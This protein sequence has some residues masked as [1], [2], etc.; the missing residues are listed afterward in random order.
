LANK[1]LTFLDTSVLINAALGKDPA[2][3][4]RALS[5][6]SDARREFASSFFLKLELLPIPTFHKITA[7]VRLYQHYF[8]NVSVWGD[9]ADFVQD[10]YP[11]AEQYGL[12]AM[13]ALH[14]AAA[15]HVNAEFISAERPTKPIYQA[16]SNAVSIY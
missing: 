10:S 3:R 4:F 7:Q 2:R 12:G 9:E 6:L 5:I 1:I 8:S 16:Y 15:A 14:V 13:D 11:L